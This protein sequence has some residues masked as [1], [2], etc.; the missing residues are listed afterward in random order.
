MALIYLLSIFFCMSLGALSEVA[1]CVYTLSMV[2]TWAI[3]L[4]LLSLLLIVLHRLSLQKGFRSIQRLQTPISWHH[5][6]GGQHP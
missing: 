5:H 2:P 1:M 6:G 4:A 3:G